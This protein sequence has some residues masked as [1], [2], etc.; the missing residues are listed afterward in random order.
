MPDAASVLIGPAEIALTR[1]FF[2]PRSAACAG[3]P[4]NASRPSSEATRARASVRRS[5]RA[6]GRAGAVESGRELIEIGLADH[7]GA[8]RAEL[9]DHRRIDAHLMREGGAGRGGRETGNVDIVLHRKGNAPQRQAVRDRR[10]GDQRAGLV[11]QLGK[12]RAADERRRIGRI[13]P[14]RQRLGET[15]RA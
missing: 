14:R 2:S 12:R 3:G 6:V 4:E 1:M 5:A 15:V 8:R 10:P 13:D 9:A 11:E 7:D